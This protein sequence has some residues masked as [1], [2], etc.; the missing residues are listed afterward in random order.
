[1]VLQQRRVLGVPDVQSAQR[2]AGQLAPARKLVDILAR[3][4][5]A[6]SEARVPSVELSRDHAHGRHQTGRHLQHLPGRE[7]RADARL[8]RDE[9]GRLDACAQP[10]QSAQ[11]VVRPRVDRL[12]GGL[13]RPRRQLLDRPQG[14]AGAHLSAADELA[15]RGRLGRPRRGVHRVS[16]RAH[17]SGVAALQARP[18]RQQSWHSIRLDVNHSQRTSLLHQG[19]TTR[20]TISINS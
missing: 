6:Q 5:D 14:A 11:L 9:E 2:L 18:Q 3:Q 13:R 1:M 12:Q 17:L 4:N 20:L 15:H 16:H 7:R 10:H 19:S 8:L